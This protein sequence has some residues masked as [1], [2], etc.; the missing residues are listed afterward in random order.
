MNQM[1]IRRS[2]SKE[3]RRVSITNGFLKV[4]PTALTVCLL[5]VGGFLYATRWIGYQSQKHFLVIGSYYDF[6]FFILNFDIIQF[7]ALRFVIIS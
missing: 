3:L 1:H 5:K 6:D 2:G 7:K 4:G